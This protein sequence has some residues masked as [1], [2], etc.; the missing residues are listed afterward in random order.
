MEKQRMPFGVEGLIDPHDMTRPVL[1]AWYRW[2]LSGQNGELEDAQIVQFTR[3]DRGPGMEPLFFPDFCQQ[4]PTDASL[5][6]APEEK[7]YALRVGR[8][9][10]APTTCRSWNG[11]PLARAFDCY[12]PFNNQLQE[13]LFNLTTP[14]YPLSELV[15]LLELMEDNGAIHTVDPSPTH[16]SNAHFPTDI[17]DDRIWSFIGANLLPTSFFVLEHPEHDSLALSTLS[18]WLKAPNRFR[19]P[20]SNTWRGG[21]KGARWIVIAAARIVTTMIVLQSPG[22]AAMELESA[23]DAPLL[24]RQG[25]QLETFL[26]WVVSSFTDSVSTLRASIADRR[27]AW[28]LAV[29][30]AHLK[31]QVSTR[32]ETA[33]FTC[34]VTNGVPLDTAELS[35]CYRRISSSDPDVTLGENNDLDLPA[36]PAPRSQRRRPRPR[37]RVE[38]DESEAESSAEHITIDEDLLS[39]SSDDDQLS[40]RY[41][42][43]FLK[44]ESPDVPQLDEPSWEDAT[45][46]SERHTFS[47]GVGSLDADTAKFEH[48]ST[49]DAEAVK[50]DESDSDDPSQSVLPIEIT[51]PESS[52]PELPTQPLPVRRTARSHV[53]LPAAQAFIDEARGR[54]G[55]K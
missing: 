55:A 24:T 4:P 25:R 13:T 31:N 42:A 26:Q 3:V 34:A 2:I 46:S 47:H 53:R 16:T 5:K 14:Q 6:Y 33:T 54:K 8:G 44:D 1:E 7:L 29:T 32:P 37:Y 48:K 35:A 50:E 22:K 45:L 52:P 40:D 43:S 30:T 27:N 17:S 19:H 51:A 36:P 23:I 18:N 11:L 38:S 39:S 10:D 9:L 28:K 21:P 49:G 20:Q 15:D 41:I 12:R